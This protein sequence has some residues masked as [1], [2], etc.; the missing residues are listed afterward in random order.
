MKLHIHHIQLVV[1]RMRKATLKL[2]RK[3]FK[4]LQ[5]ETKYLGHLITTEGI[6]A[7]PAKIE[8]LTCYK[9]P[10]TQKQLR[11]FIGFVTF[12][13]RY[14][15]SFANICSPL[16]KCSTSKTIEWDQDCQQAFDK[17]RNAITVDIILI[18]PDMNST[19][20]LE[21][22]ACEYGVGAVLSQER[23]SEVRPIPFFS[24]HLGA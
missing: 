18:F 5:K 22:D 11:A 6:K 15:K 17:L 10:T 1:D 20:I 3:K 24:K 8:A 7:D 13:R 23:N 9:K 2:K 21:T 14:I 19:F 12:Y 16:Y 4:P